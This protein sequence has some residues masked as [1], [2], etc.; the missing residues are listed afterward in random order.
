M[1]NFTLNAIPRG[2]ELQG[3]GSSRRLR[4]QNLI[5][6]I[7]YGGNEEPTPVSL[8]MNELVKVL[9]D[10]AFFS[11]IIT[12]N[13]E[14]GEEEQGIIKALQRHPAKNQPMHADFQRI[15]RGQK[16]SMSIPV[17]F[18]GRD[19]SPGI[20]AGGNLSTLVADVD[21]SCLPMNIPEYIV[22]DV[23]NLN[24]GESLHL[25]D[26]TLP[27]GVTLDELEAGADGTDRTVANIQA[28]RAEK[29][30]APADAEEAT[31]ASEEE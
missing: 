9:E 10:E 20:K 8:K 15:V 25:S 2:E 22:V 3:K 26:I 28:P 11:S 7:I 6:A 24:V 31:E 12:I 23:S 13:V 27:E 19:V 18:E 14:G 29:E 16:I 30:E 1:K 4:K 17:H 5:P 21:V